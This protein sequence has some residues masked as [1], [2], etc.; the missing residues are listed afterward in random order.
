MSKRSSTLVT[1]W[2]VASLHPFARDAFVEEHRDDNLSDAEI[3]SR[4][5]DMLSSDS[6][7]MEDEFEKFSF[8][9][10][11]I[12]SKVFKKGECAVAGKNTD[13]RGRS[14]HIPC[15]KYKDGMALLNAITP[16]SG[17]Y[18]ARVWECRNN[19]LG[20]YLTFIISH[21]DVPTGSSCLVV[22]PKYFNTAMK[23]T[24]IPSLKEEVKQ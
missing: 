11:E 14:G 16:K 4:V 21:H 18:T 8:S 9:V 10:N 6:C 17:D 13:W 2:D 22:R 23:L 15:A 19:M 5:Q 7:F 24:E 1:L 3:D 20:H 12:F